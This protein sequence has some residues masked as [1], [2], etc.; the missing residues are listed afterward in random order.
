MVKN[1]PLFYWKPNPGGQVSA[2]TST[3]DILFISGANRSG[4]STLLCHLAAAVMLPHPEDTDKSF[5]PCL[6][7][8]TSKNPFSNSTTDELR[9]R[10]HI[11]LPAI[12]W[13]STR[14]M[15]GHKDVVMDHMPELL[16]NYIEKVEWSDEPGVWSRVI[17]D[18]GS[19]LHLKSAGQ[20]LSGF[21]R[22]NINLMINDEPFPETIYGEQL[23]RLL[24]RR[25][26]MIIGATA[27][28]N[29]MD[30][31]AFR[32]S[33]WLIERFAQPAA[34]DELPDNVEVI[35]IPLSE[36]P[37]ID[38][39]YALGMYSMLSDLEKRARYDGEM[40]SLQGEC[41]FNREILKG[42]QEDCYPPAVGYLDEELNFVEEYNLGKQATLRVW[43][44]PEKGVNYM[45]GIDPSS[46]G[47]DPSVI[48]V[49]S[50]SP[51]TLVAE[52]R[53]WMAEERLP[54]EIIKLAHWYMDGLKGRRIRNVAVVIEVN[55][56]RLTLSAMQHGNT[57]LGVKDPLPLIY[58]RP[59]P[60]YLNR[61]LHFPSDQPGFMT[62]SAN[63]GFILS[64]AQ[65]MLATSLNSEQIM[66]P[67]ANSLTDD[68]YWFVWNNGKPQAHK[69]HHDDRVIADGLAWLGFKQHIFKDQ[70]EEEENILT[71]SPF[72]S[73]GSNIGFDPF[74]A[75][76]IHDKGLEE[77]NLIYG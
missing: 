29:D 57:E 33:E 63:R 34:L 7:D 48:R 41:Y 1:S 32:E 25:G 51:R 42:L 60:S 6:P 65:N 75:I 19:E 15:A 12:V 46:G 39:N 3:K 8:W 16:D 24:D 62:S 55:Q 30:S 18:N 43:L 49:W 17:L 36:N 73:N 56:G 47:D 20:G 27:I 23:A 68:Y 76:E 44:E 10:R 74:A 26:R 40:I 14:N 70:I 38:K 69:G 4:K 54:R 5:W 9:D 11:E 37:H 35:P 59:K 22:S 28:A 58:H 21:Q 52:L 64:C 31:K 72:S 50:D 13:F 77:G 67:D 66:M 71:D 2:W 53:G 61:G 45:F